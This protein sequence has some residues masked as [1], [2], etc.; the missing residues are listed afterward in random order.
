MARTKG[1]K[2]SDK[3]APVTE[4][5]DPP[6]PEAVA[7]VV[8]TKAVTNPG[9]KALLDQI[10][11]LQAE[12]AALQ[13]EVRKSKQE[14]AALEQVQSQ[15]S[16][17]GIASTERATGKF[18]MVSRLK[19]YKVTGWENGRE[20]LKPEFHQVKRETYL[21]KVDMPPCGDIAL[22]IND[23]PFYHGGVYELD[24]D[25]LRTIKDIVARTWDHDR[26]ISGDRNENAY[27][28]RHENFDPR[29]VLRGG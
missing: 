8:S 23:V 5:T 13:G 10:A 6:T 4:A 9:Q 28:R 21:Y 26:Q 24:I 20:I 22:K 25:T 7:K 3:S 19:R 27:R 2:K 1:T 12:K 18:V 11:K 29:N 16:I 17:F 14:I 15:G